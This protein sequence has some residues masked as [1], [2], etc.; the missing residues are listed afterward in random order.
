MSDNRKRA[1]RWA[2]GAFVVCLVPLGARVWLEQNGAVERAD[3]GAVGEFIL[4]DDS[5]SAL[6]RD[7]LRRS[8]TIVIYWPKKCEDPQSCHGA[9]DAVKKVQNWVA[10][11]LQPRWTEEKNPL[12]LFVAGESAVELPRLPSWRIFPGV[13]DP[14]TIIPGRLDTSKPHVVVIDNNLLFAASEDL[15]QG[16]NFEKLERVLSKTAF[17]QYLGNYLSGRTFMGPKRHQN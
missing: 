15:E 10:D 11:S 1:L 12:N 3:L 8:V 5:G 14:G 6:N 13:V 16:V 2:L 9:R 7:Q 17:D 4:R